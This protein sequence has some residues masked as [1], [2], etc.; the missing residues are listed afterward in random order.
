MT[1][2]F[3]FEEI[4]SSRPITTDPPAVTLKYKA[5]GEANEQFVLAYAIAN[6]F[7]F[8][9]TSMGTLW[10]QPISIEPDG[11]AQYIVTVPYGRKKQDVL[12]V[13]FAF[14]TGGG[15]I[16]I[17]ASRATRN[18]Y[19][20]AGEAGNIP[21]HGGA[22]G[23]GADGAVEGVDVVI[24]SLRM[25]YSFRH[26]QGIV[27]EATAITLARATGKVNSA[28]FRGF[29]PGEL[30]FL[31]ANGGDGTDAEATV[32]YDF[33]ASENIASMSIGAIANIA[34]RGHDYLW[35]SFEPAADE[36]RA[37]QKPLFAYV[38][39]VYEEIDFAAVLG[40]S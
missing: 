36:G 5:A 39:Q 26:P 27:N 25:T 15:S 13:N 33:A 22:I 38:E 12:S 20:A 7:N 10:R 23:V 28:T 1:I 30:L 6:T 29:P 19:K 9:F 21:D 4:P 3:T 16:R 2:N 32:A 17:K 40:W 14:S 18:S 24:P 35:I 37:V 8:V 11:F 34:K 31:G